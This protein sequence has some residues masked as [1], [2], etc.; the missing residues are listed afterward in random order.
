[1]CLLVENFN[2]TVHCRSEVINKTGGNVVLSFQ[3]LIREILGVTKDR[4]Q[5]VTMVSITSKL[6]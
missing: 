4:I 5:N 1:M 3:K 2:E 6:Q